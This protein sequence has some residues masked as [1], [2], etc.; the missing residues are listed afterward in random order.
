MFICT[1]RMVTTDGRREVTEFRELIQGGGTL[2]VIRDIGRCLGSQIAGSLLG[3]H[4]C[5][6]SVFPEH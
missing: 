4:L 1:L 3:F 5:L 6:S 2:A